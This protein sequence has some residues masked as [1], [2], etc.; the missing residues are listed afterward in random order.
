[1]SFNSFSTP[2]SSQENI[3]QSLNDLYS[4]NT[5]LFALDDEVAINQVLKEKVVVLDDLMKLLKKA[6]R[7]RQFSAVDQT[8][9]NFLVSRIEINAEKGN[10][11][12]AGRDKIKLEELKTNQLIKQYLEYLIVSSKNYRY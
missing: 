3:V 5:K 10:Q 7:S 12:A 11:L 4:I 8:K 9:L 2:S 1:M 6:V